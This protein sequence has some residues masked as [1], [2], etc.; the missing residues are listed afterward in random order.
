ML[1]P[2]LGRKTAVVTIAIF[3]WFPLGTELAGSGQGQEDPLSKA[4]ELI[5]KGDYEGAIKILKDYIAKIRMIAAQKKN[6]AEAYY[7]IAK[8]YYIVGNEENSETNIRKTF[9]SFPAFT[10]DEPDLAF[11]GRAEKARIVVQEEQKGKEGE[12][13]LEA[14]KAK[15][16]DKRPSAA[17]QV[18]AAKKREF[19]WLIAAGVALAGGA[20]AILA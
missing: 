3:L 9:E 14:E 1:S 18:G 20:A 7:I 12:K 19:P 17:G 11:R 10:T 5:R 16:K 13:P 15:K 4:R 8:I 2:G 6:I